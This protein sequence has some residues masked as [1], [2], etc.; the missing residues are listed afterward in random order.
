MNIRYLVILTVLALVVAPVAADAA[1]LISV[2]SVSG[3][4]VSGPT[5][6][7]VQSWDVEAGETYKLTISHVAECANGG[8]D[9]TLN[10]RI[11]STTHGN[12]D[13][14]ATYVSP[15]VYEFEYTLPADAVCTFPI[16]Y[17]TTPGQYNTGLYVMRDDGGMFQA[18][19]RASTF[20]A[21]CTNPTENK[22]P[23]CL[24]VP[25]EES[26]WGKV[27]ALYD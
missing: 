19:L 17:C 22:G 14:V 15:G 8:S 12:T 6:P 18:H 7:S 1:R 4:C 9:P 13:I 5:G 20:E 23:D 24:V 21:G 27:K 26:S 3:G 25:N 11:N 10:V 16:F 2:T